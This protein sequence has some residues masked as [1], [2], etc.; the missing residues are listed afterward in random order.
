M[1]EKPPPKKRGRKSKKTLEAEAKLK[2]NVV[3]EPVKVP[4]NVDENPKGVKLFNNLSILVACLK[5]NQMLFC[6]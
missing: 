5:P 4:K 6:I 2:N 1:Q 3:A